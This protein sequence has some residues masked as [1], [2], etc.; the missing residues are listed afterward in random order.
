LGRVSHL[1]VSRARALLFTSVGHFINDGSVFF[2]PLI[3]DLLLALKGITPLEV[4]VLLSVFY[5]VS[6]VASVAVGKLADKTGKPAGLMAL[7]IACLGLGLV[8]FDLIILYSSGG[9]FFVFAL[10]CDL[11]MGVGSSFYHPLGGS[12]LQ[13]AFGHE[14]SGRALG[15]N[16]SMGSVGRALYPSLFYVAAAAFNKPGSLGFFGLVG[17]G[18]AVLIWTG[19]GQA[20]ASKPTGRAEGPSV[21]SSLTRPMLVLLGVSFIRSAALFG[22]TAYIPIFLSTQRNLGTG[23]LLF[24]SLTAFYASAILGQP[25]FGLLVE[26][27]DHRSVLAISSLGAAASMVGYVN[28]GGVE[29]IIM[30]SLFGFFTYTG[31]PL[32]MSLAA[33]YATENASNL[34][35]SLVWGLGANGGNSIG[36]VL[37]YALSLNDYS[38]LGG[39]FEVMAAL[40]VA[41]AMG[42]FLIP[43]PS[44][45][46]RGSQG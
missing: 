44:Y 12:I 20:E 6:T 28:S 43:K 34:G 39:S 17:L 37:V 38:R 27:I 32:L 19:I 36:P 29:G 33:D 13:T 26:R 25:L 7:G 5:L 10:L 45:K 18:S 3:V 31:F 22:I 1:T 16:G 21:R 2:V 4:S 14:K 11:V 41:S 40:A 23:P 42:A 30:L 15:L 35:N 9:E 46:R 24:L 8:G